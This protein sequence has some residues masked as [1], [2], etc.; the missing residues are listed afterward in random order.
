VGGLISHALC[1]SRPE[2]INKKELGSFHTHTF[3]ASAGVSR[4]GS[5][6]SDDDD[7]GG[8][9]DGGGSVSAFDGYSLSGS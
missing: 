4:A 9:G 1:I 8:G 2:K 7:G 5:K 6:T 3:A